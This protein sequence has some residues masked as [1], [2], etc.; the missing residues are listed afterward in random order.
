M[1]LT[2]RVSPIILRIN[3]QGDVT[4]DSMTGYNCALEYTQEVSF[5][6]Q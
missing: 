2:W 6:L 5:C 3:A 4:D 1:S